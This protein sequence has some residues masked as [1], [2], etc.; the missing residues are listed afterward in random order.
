MQSEVLGAGGRAAAGELDQRADDRGDEQPFPLGDRLGGRFA[1]WRPRASRRPGGRGARRSPPRRAGR[2]PTAA[3]RARSGRCAAI[4]PAPPS[5]ARRRTGAQRPRHRRRVRPRGRS[6]VYGTYV[7]DVR[8]RV[9]AHGQVQGVFFRDSTRREAERLGVSGWASNERRR[10]GGDGLRRAGGGGGGD[11]RVR[12]RLAGAL[13]CV[14]RGRVVRGTPE[15]L[16]G[17]STR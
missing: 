15:G 5:G 7:A 2:A 16:S 6:F 14:V 12:S 1:A 17:F 4:P 11:D 10:H 9:V 3:W 13:L 8:S